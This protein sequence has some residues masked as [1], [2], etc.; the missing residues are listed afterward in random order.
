MSTTTTYLITAFIAIS[1]FIIL[2]EFFCWYWKIN[3]MKALME[4]QRDIMM[5]KIASQNV[6]VNVHFQPLPLFTAYKKLGFSMND[7]PE[8]FKQYSREI[9]LPVFYDI[10]DEQIEAVV[11]A[12][13]TA[14]ESLT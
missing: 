10:S 4:E 6:A 9:T 11:N 7:F 3:S 12:V 2:R 1:L 14:Y 5:D 13:S 8:A